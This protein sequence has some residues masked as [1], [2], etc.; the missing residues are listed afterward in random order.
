MR[1][2]KRMNLLLVLLAAM[3]LLSACGQGKKEPTEK[4]AKEYV[5]ASFKAFLTGDADDYIKITGESKEEVEKEYEEILG[6]M[7]DDMESIA[8]FKGDSAE[9]CVNASKKMLASTKYEVGEA[10]KDKDGNFQVEVTVYPSDVF[11]VIMQKS[12]ELATSYNVDE[13]LGMLVAE[14]FEQAVDE[15]SFGEAVSYQVAVNK[16]SEGRYVI[17]DEDLQTVVFGMFEEAS[18]VFEGSGKVYDNPCFN[19]KK[20]E[21]DAA[22]DEEKN[23]CC[24]AIVQYLYGFT[25]EQM[26]TIDL[27]DANIQSSIQ[28]I[29][30]GVDLAYAGGVDFSIGDYVELIKGSGV[31][32]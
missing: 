3:M 15:Q 32:E 5:Q 19:W 17:D 9:K 14:A 13:D 1:K 28:Q 11:N 6:I 31:F 12:M 24:L 21:W 27:N 2:L 20:A 8:D 30:E 7:K 26:A 23:Q 29:K 18:N 4:E 10:K 25:D 16:D 22:P